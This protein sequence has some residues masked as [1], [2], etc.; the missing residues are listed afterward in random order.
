M[1]KTM[2]Y[3]HEEKNINGRFK[4]MT[5]NDIK[6]LCAQNKPNNFQV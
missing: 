6:L 2:V 5:E 1:E 3:W 4:Q